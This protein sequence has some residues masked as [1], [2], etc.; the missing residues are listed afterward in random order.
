MILI[1]VWKK[2]RKAKAERS[3]ISKSRKARKAAWVDWEA[4]AP[5]SS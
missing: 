1:G 2:E 4:E 3:G 5:C